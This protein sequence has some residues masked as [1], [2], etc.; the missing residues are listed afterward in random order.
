MRALV[1]GRAVALAPRAAEQ[2]FPSEEA[3]RVR[4][5]FTDA[6]LVHREDSVAYWSAGF[7]CADPRDPAALPNLTSVSVRLRR[8][9]TRWLAESD[10]S[11]GSAPSRAGAC[12]RIR[13][14]CV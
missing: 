4:C 13:S 14:G 5:T 2:A 12:A 8:D 1:A 6:R 7:S 9:G 10:A 11:G 3:A